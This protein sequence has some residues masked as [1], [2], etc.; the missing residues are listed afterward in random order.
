MST[1]YDAQRKLEREKKL[2]EKKRLEEER[3]HFQI[4]LLEEQNGKFDCTKQPTE[5]QKFSK[6]Y[7]ESC[8]KKAMDIVS[9]I[10]SK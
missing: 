10:Q 6:R 2:K 8:K 4:N 9:K 1:P 7:I 5:K 3:T